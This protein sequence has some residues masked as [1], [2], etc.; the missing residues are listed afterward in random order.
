M[1]NLKLLFSLSKRNIKLYFKDKTT[2]FLSLITPFI[3]L[4]LFVL[5][6]KN[7][8]IS[9]LESVIEPLNINISS[10]IK[11]GFVSSWLV[12]SIVSTSAVSVS[13][14]S[15]TLMVNDKLNNTSID[16]DV[17]PVPS[18]IKRLSYLIS[19]FVSTTLIM[20]IVLLIGFTYIGIV[21]WY[22]TFFDVIKILLSTI[23]LTLFGSTLSCIVFSFIKSQGGISTIATLVSSCYGFLSGAYTPLSQY[24]KIMVSILGFNPG[25][26]GNCI[27]KSSFMSGAVDKIGEATPI[28]YNS[29]ISEIK[30]EFDLNYYFFDNYINIKMC[31]L[32][33]SCIGAILLGI[34]LLMAYKAKKKQ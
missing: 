34:Y 3:L 5:F 23:L 32:I 21:G 18:Y 33:L 9:A 20:F 2:F 16:I 28:E 29:I 13:F 14:C 8:Y 30:N 26:Y 17:S 31:F 10:Q 11:E 27:L 19:T 22:L 7:T 24:P 4:I 1:G 6:L 15:S 12:S 25:I